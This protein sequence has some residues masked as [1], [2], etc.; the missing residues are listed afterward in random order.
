MTTKI[1]IARFLA[2]CG[3]NS[4]RK[5]EAL[6]TEGRVKVNGITV[7]QLYFKVDSE[8]D[9]VEYNGKPLIIE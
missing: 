1:R 7:N 3:V 4:R 9:R 5:C 6:I 2:E 8:K